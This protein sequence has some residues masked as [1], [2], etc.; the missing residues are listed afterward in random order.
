MAGGTW[1]GDIGTMPGGIDG[2]AI[3]EGSV[4]LLVTSLVT[5]LIIRST[6]SVFV[7]NHV[8]ET[9]VEEP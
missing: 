5:A 4:M 7:S 8:V 2:S 9:V 1:P 3:G 6:W